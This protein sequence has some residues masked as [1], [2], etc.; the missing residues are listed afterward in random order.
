MTVRYTLRMAES[1]E[2]KSKMNPG[3]AREHEL[4]G[5]GRIVEAPVLPNESDVPAMLLGD[6]MPSI[7][8]RYHAAKFYMDARGGELKNNFAKIVA[9]AERL[10]TGGYKG[11]ENAF[12]VDA[13][14]IYVEKEK[15]LS[16][17]DP[18]LIPELLTQYVKAGLNSKD[19]SLINVYERR[20]ELKPIRESKGSSGVDVDITRD[21]ASVMGYDV[22]RR[23]G[24]E[25]RVICSEL[26]F[27]P[28]S[29]LE[30][31]TVH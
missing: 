26:R 7:D 3:S 24:E 13:K 9:I 20:G 21:I 5:L 23:F 17:L 1:I 4:R 22:V 11:N 19:K 10:K 28:K 2:L 29:E 12:D 30:R 18:E 15:L 27:V 16:D 25:G 31:D 14:A 8:S 6:D